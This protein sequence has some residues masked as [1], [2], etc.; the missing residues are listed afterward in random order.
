MDERLVVR[1]LLP[2][3]GSEVE[4]PRYNLNDSGGEG[5]YYSCSFPPSDRRLQAVGV[6][7][8]HSTI[9]PDIR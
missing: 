8:V 3:K 5:G 7:L 4:Q 6:H 2:V 9:A 1:S